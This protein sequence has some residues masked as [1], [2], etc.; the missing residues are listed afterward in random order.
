MFD[1]RFLRCQGTV[2]GERPACRRHPQ[3]AWQVR[4][5]SPPSSSQGHQR[6]QPRSLLGTL[7][8]LPEQGSTRPRPPPPQKFQPTQ[9]PRPSPERQSPSPRPLIIASPP[10]V[11]IP[12]PTI[13]LHLQARPEPQSGSHDQ[14]GACPRPTMASE[15]RTSHT[16]PQRRRP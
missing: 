14:A 16:G 2:W 7:P 9:P 5:S 13:P 10:C 4:T 11:S 3:C 1:P 6:L 8:T 15:R 12:D